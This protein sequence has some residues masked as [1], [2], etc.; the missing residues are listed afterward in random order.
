V[1]Y[2]SP[3]LGEGFMHLSEGWLLFVVA[4]VFLGGLTW[5]VSTLERMA[6]RRP[7]DV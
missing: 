3:K 4:F 6:P 2:V 7:V 1:Y 5:L